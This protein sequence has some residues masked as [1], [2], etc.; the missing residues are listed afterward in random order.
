[1]KRNLAVFLLIILSGCDDKKV[2]TPP[3]TAEQNKEL[4]VFLSRVRADMV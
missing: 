3:L 4:D 1:M 2:V